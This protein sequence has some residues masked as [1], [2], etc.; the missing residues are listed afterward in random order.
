MTTQG[1]AMASTSSVHPPSSG[2][3]FMPPAINTQP[4]AMPQ[5]QQQI[6]AT[7]PFFFST[8]TGSGIQHTPAMTMAGKFLS[9]SEG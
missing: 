8:V 1:G 6:Q 3:R 9:Q 5:S 4:A 2:F 7:H